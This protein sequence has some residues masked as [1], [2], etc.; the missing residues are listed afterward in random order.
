[1]TSRPVRPR[2]GDFLARWAWLFYLPLIATAFFV[3][4]PG[5]FRVTDWLRFAS[6]IGA[7]GAGTALVVAA[8]R[9]ASRRTAWGRRLHAEFHAV[10]AGLESGRILLL[11]LLSAFGEEILFRGVLQPWLGL[12]FTSLLFGLFHF[13]VKRALVPWS[14]MAGLL[15]L[16]L[17]GL[18]LYAQ[19]LWPAIL[20]HFGINYFN[21]HDLAQGEVPASPHAAPPPS[22]NGGPSAGHS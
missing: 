18:T 3:Q 10:L 15:G 13:P 6:G 1:M 7:A 16:G 9:W 12:W 17:G 19:S 22:G 11:S 4:E 14:I 20:L 2:P 5:T 8:S 21:L